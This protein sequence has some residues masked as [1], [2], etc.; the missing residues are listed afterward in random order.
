MS[1]PLDSGDSGTLIT[2]PVPLRPSDYGRAGNGSSGDIELNWL[3]SRDEFGGPH[4][5]FVFPISGDRHFRPPDPPARH[6][7]R[8]SPQGEGGLFAVSHFNQKSKIGNRKCPQ[9]PRHLVT[10]SP[11]VPLC[12]LP[13]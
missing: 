7:V 5:D 11:S 9:L 8:Q 6:L 12:V 13:M 1:I 10:Q 3:D 4:T 2:V